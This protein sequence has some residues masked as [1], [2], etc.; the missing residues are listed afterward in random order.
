MRKPKTPPEEEVGFDA[1][2][3][4]LRRALEEHFA[5][6]PPQDEAVAPK[7]VRL[8]TA[9]ERDLFRVEMAYRIQAVLC[10]DPGRC[11]KHRCRR[12]SRC[13]ELEDIAPLVEEQRALVAKERAAAAAA[14]DA[15]EQVAEAD[16]DRRP[17]ARRRAR[18]G[19]TEV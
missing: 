19:K 8:E 4:N 3:A 14:A 18:A 13:Q 2:F 7:P 15:G 9:A 17:G 6:L 11:G 1:G 16:P 12:L 10:P 5:R